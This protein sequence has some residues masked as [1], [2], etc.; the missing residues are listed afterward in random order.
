MLNGGFGEP[1][2]KYRA[3]GFRGSVFVGVLFGGLAP[4]RFCVGVLFLRLRYGLCQVMPDYFFVVLFC[5]LY[6]FYC[7]EFVWFVAY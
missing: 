5:F 4:P 1:E 2:V 3:V 7:Y 6:F